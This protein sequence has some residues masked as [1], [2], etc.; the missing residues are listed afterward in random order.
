M[1]LLDHPRW[2]EIAPYVRVETYSRDGGHHHPRHRLEVLR[3]PNIRRFTDVHMP[4]VACGA[5]I[6]PIRL[7]NGR[8]RV[9]CYLAVTCSLSVRYACARSRAAAVEYE[10]IVAAVLAGATRRPQA[11][12]FDWGG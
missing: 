11:L 1:S 5:L 6:H 4:C 8:G 7:R 10:R 2:P 9:H 3:P 12:A